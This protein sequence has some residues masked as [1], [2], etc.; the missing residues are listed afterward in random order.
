[1]IFPDIE[2][3]DDLPKDTIAFVSPRKYDMA[4]VNGELT[5]ILEPEAEWA[6]RCAIITN[7]GKEGS[8]A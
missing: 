3:R 2:I 7:V 5:L 4:L 1:M 6:K 8:A